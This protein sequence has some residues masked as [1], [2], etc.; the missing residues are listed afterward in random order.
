MLEVFVVDDSPAIRSSV[1]LILKSGGMKASEAVSAE[2]ALDKLKGGALKPNLFIVDL[3]MPGMNG[4]DLIKQIR[5]MPAFRFVPILMM[6]TESQQ[7]KRAEA[8][9][10]GA[11]GWLVKPVPPADLLKVVKQVCPSA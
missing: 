3:N 6:T 7:A 1:S 5:A 4:I 2:D 10:A 9:S 11:T 8:K